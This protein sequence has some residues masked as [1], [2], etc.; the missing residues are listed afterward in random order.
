MT[1]KPSDIG[2][3]L[4]AHRTEYQRAELQRAELDA[5]PL[6]MF[7]QWLEQAQ[8]SGMLD[9]TAMTLATSTTTG[10]PSARIVLLKQFDSDGFCWYTGYE[11]RKGKELAENPHAALLF[12]WSALERQIRI[13]GKVE[14]VTPQQSDQD[15]KSRPPGSQFSAA[16]S[17]LLYTSPSPRD[18]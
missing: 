13:E 17:C 3:D 2:A 4:H 18:S 15:F 10:M 8:N 14:K 16:T 9:A 7:S 1:D 6:S 11:S 12:Y 5:N